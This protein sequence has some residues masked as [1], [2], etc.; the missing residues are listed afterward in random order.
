MGTYRDVPNESNLDH[1]KDFND[2]WSGRVG[3]GPQGIDWGT[4]DAIMS[5]GPLVG[6][7]PQGP[8][9]PGTEPPAA[10]QAPQA[11]QFDPYSPANGP[12]R[13]GGV[14][15]GPASWDQIGAGMNPNGNRMGL[16]GSVPYDG[17]FGLMGP[18]VDPLSVYAGSFP[19]GLPQNGPMPPARPG[20]APAYAALGAPATTQPMPTPSGGNDGG[21]GGQNFTGGSVRGGTPGATS[22]YGT[23]YDGAGLSMPHDKDFA[24]LAG[25]AIGGQPAAP[26]GG[27]P[28]GMSIP[29]LIG[30]GLGLVAGGIP[31]AIGG[32]QIGK[33]VGSLSD[34][35]GG[36]LGGG[37]QGGGMNVMDGQ[38]GFRAADKMDAMSNPDVAQGMFG[39][40]GGILGGGFD[41]GGMFGGQGGAPGSA[42]SRGE[43]SFGGD[44]SQDGG[45]RYS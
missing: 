15:L 6:G 32:Y 8:A 35:I 36:I 23:P 3:G 45:A 16:P 22:S 37:G 11:Q 21:W 27:G 14:G 33:G 5:A 38:G 1:N 26:A 25:Q 34:M 19:T 30:G 13:P 9:F 10:P 28:F 17:H 24:S 18:A 41:F 4:F 40:G 43:G 42:T 31:G 29:G 44:P 7:M 39:G 12:G 20:T 2:P